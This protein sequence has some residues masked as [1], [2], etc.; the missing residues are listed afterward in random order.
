VLSSQKANDN[1]PTTTAPKIPETRDWLTRNEASDML[2]CSHQ[3]LA[4]YE[5]RGDLH[6][7]FAYRPDGRGAE[8]RVIVYNP[9]ELKKLAIKLR[10][11]VLQPRDPGEMAARAFE[12]FRE[13][14]SMEDV[15]VEL[16]LLPDQVRELHDKRLE[17]GGADLV[18]HPLAKEALEKI[19]GPFK[20][21]TELVEGVGRLKGAAT[22]K[23][24]PEVDG[25]PTRGT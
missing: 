8:H 14:K 7:Q 4:N 18:I 21:V 16:R 2:T 3:T 9:H 24:S 11:H 23:S 5:R 6:P 10:R 20:D 19:I 25:N 1:G 22:V 15:V 12:L 17:L 13:G